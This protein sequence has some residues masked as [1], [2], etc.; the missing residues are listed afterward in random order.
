MIE[1]TIPF[2]PVRDLVMILRVISI[3][4]ILYMAY[5]TAKKIKEYHILSAT[6]GFTVFLATFA[7]FHFGS[8]IHYFYP[9]SESSFYIFD[10]IGTYS[11]VIGMVLFVFLSELD[12]KINLKEDSRKVKFNYPLTFL[13]FIGVLIITIICIF[14]RISIV[15]VFVF[16]VIPF[17]IAVFEFTK[18]FSELKIVKKSNPTTWF[19]AGISIAGFSNFLYSQFLTSFIDIYIIMSLISLCVITGCLMMT[20]GWNSL[21][22]LQEFYW[23]KKIDRLLVVHRE[24]SLLLLE[25]N[26]HTVENTD[27]DLA[28][29]A[30]SG[31]DMLLTEILSS[32]GHIQQIDHEDKKI[33]F[34]HGE[35]TV[36]IL[37]TTGDSEEYKYRLELFE[38]DFERKYGVSALKNF[39]GDLSIF[40]DSEELVKKHF[41]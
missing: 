36:S 3:L 10:Y 40:D 8:G 34:T 19:A 26:F 5:Q 16:A 12:I 20:K 31:I 30:I 41:F 33:Y 23:M 14:L 25:Y 37:I 13:D 2:S 32:K 15:F 22:S 21:P 4:A 35:H 28:G 29:S 17:V 27:G 38:L 39:D 18:R 9:S 24:M 1:Q 6:T 7:V 11:F